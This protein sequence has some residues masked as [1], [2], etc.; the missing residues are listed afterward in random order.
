LPKRASFNHGGRAFF[1][2]VVL[3]IRAANASTVRLSGASAARGSR[4]KRDGDGGAAH[5]WRPVSASGR[6]AA[7]R[8]ENEISKAARCVTIRK[9]NYPRPERLLAGVSFAEWSRPVR[10]CA[11]SAIQCLAFAPTINLQPLMIMSDGDITSRN[12][13]M[14]PAALLYARH[15]GSSQRAAVA[16]RPTSWHAPVALFGKSNHSIGVAAQR[17]LDW[18]RPRR[19]RGRGRLPAWRHYSAAGRARSAGRG[20]RDAPPFALAYNR[21]SSRLL[22]STRISR[23]PP[24]CT[25]SS[26]TASS[27]I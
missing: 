11:G 14:V 8:I 20:R 5:D 12:P 9:I 24:T 22:Q 17:Y 18:P 2:A 21:L 1:G 7:E 3:R 26:S 4:R 15:G 27:S 25:L 10:G 19:L 6:L 13:S 23:R 16:C